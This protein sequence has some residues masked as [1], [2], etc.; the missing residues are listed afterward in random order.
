M[1]REISGSVKLSGVETEKLVSYL[2][3]KELEA[4]KKAGT[5]KGTFA[6][7][8]HF[9]GYQGR[10]GHPSKFDCSLGSTYGFASGVLIENEVTGVVASIS[11]LTLPPSQWRAGAVP[12]LS[13]L[14]SFPKEGY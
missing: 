6:A 14:Q 4:R 2:V 1:E 13:L 5:Y 12:I 7:V 9:F 10:C 11:G 8:T 3:Q